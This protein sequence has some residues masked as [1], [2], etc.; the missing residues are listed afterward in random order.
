MVIECYT[1]MAMGD[2][3]IMVVH[4]YGWLYMAIEG[5]SMSSP[6]PLPAPSQLSP[7][8]ASP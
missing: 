7:P 8:S 6:L 1:I 5:S 2:Y 4:G 3:T